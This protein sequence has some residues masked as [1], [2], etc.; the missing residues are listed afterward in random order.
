M[1]MQSPLKI[2]IAK[3]Q[4]SVF[5]YQSFGNERMSGITTTR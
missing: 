4:R 1:P 3:P 5:E 2:S